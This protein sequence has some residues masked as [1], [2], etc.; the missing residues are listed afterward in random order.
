MHDDVARHHSE[1]DGSR[2]TIAFFDWTS[3]FIYLFHPERERGRAR[4]QKPIDALEFFL[5][6]MSCLTKRSSARNFSTRHT[7]MLMTWCARGITQLNYISLCSVQKKT[8]GFLCTIS[9]RV[10]GWWCGEDLEI[11]EHRQKTIKW[12]SVC[13]YAATSKVSE[14]KRCPRILMNF[15]SSLVRSFFGENISFLFFKIKRTEQRALSLDAC[16]LL[17]RTKVLCNRSENTWMIMINS[18]SLWSLVLWVVFSYWLSSLWPSG[19]FFVRDHNDPSY[20]GIVILSRPIGGQQGDPKRLN[21]D[22][23]QQIHR[24]RSPSIHHIWSIKMWRTLIVS[25]PVNRR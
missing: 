17:G 14:T 3:M 13:K 10:S 12:M 15:F 6:R 19:V 2:L 22:S 18:S 24:F 4:E 25:W 1:D 9:S 23:I 7:H 16:S 21:D 11:E 5:L 8:R 20:R